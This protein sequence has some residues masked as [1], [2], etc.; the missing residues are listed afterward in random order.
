MKREGESV[1][2]ARHA[3]PGLLSPRVPLQDLVGSTS[4]LQ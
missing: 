2:W 3:V 1:L 4:H